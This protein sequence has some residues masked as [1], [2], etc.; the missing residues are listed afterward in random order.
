M[1]V[2]IAK[3]EIIFGLGSELRLRGSVNKT[4]FF[5]FCKKTETPP[6]PFFDH[7][8]F[9]DKDFLTWPRPIPD[10]CYGSHGYTRV[11]FF[12]PV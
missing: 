2:I 7:L 1:N 6:P 12:W 11:N 5:T 10:I 4:V 8:S 3:Y 9:S